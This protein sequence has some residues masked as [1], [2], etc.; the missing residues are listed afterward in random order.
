MSHIPGHTKMVAVGW[1]CVIFVDVLPLFVY[2][3]DTLTSPTIPPT[4][5][6]GQCIVTGFVINSKKWSN[7]FSCCF[8]INMIKQSVSL[9][10]SPK[11]MSSNIHSG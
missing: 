7:V 6:G 10:T 1:P 4:T 11:P 5:T 2:A 3:V 8:L 9:A